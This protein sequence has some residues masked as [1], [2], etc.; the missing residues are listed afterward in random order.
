MCHDTY[1]L[2]H[3]CWLRPYRTH[4]GAIIAGLSVQDATEYANTIWKKF[5]LSNTIPKDA[6]RE[7]SRAEWLGNSR[8]FMLQIFSTIASDQGW[9]R[10]NLSRTRALM[11]TA[12]KSRTNLWTVI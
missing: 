11:W 12:H 1:I 10:Q 7:L 5:L 4:T 3:L 9:L 2:T 6:A 8:T